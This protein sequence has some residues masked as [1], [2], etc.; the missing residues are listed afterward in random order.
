MTQQRGLPGPIKVD[1]FYFEIVLMNPKDGN[2]L[3]RYGES[4]MAQKII[5]IDES[6]GP[7]QAAE[8]LIHELLHVLFKR[9]SLQKEDAE[10]RIVVQLSTGLSAI[11]HDNPT[12]GPWLLRS[13][14]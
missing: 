14:K 6:Y 9:R 5:R 7:R 3:D 2:D 11:L 1:E 13:L 10:E 12:L 4:S 8:T